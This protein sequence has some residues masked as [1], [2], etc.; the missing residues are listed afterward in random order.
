MR[1]ECKQ[2]YTLFFP[3]V[4]SE[5]SSLSR[6]SL[7]VWV[8]RCCVSW[9]QWCLHTDVQYGGSIAPMREKKGICNLKRKH[10][11]PEW[12]TFLSYLLCILKKEACQHAYL[13]TTIAPSSAQ[14]LNLYVLFCFASFLERTSFLSFLT[15]EP[16]LTFAFWMK[17]CGRWGATH[18]QNAPPHLGSIGSSA[19][20]TPG[21]SSPRNSSQV[22]T[23]CICPP[24]HAAP[25]PSALANLCLCLAAHH[26]PRPHWNLNPLRV[27]SLCPPLDRIHTRW[28]SV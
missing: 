6:K 5:Y 27:Q 2:W 11:L 21:C 20:E 7:S 14:R 8:T 28:W 26:L 22:Q 3:S 10:S 1:V 19:R 15:F 13:P 23:P 25:V 4:L 16:C 18:W 24:T 9:Q 12:S 17:T